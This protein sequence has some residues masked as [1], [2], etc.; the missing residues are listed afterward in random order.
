MAAFLIPIATSSLRGLGHILT[1][2]EAA[3]TPFTLAIPP[4]ELGPPQILSSN[5]VSRDEQGLCGGLLL[6][7]AARIEGQHTISMVVGITNESKFPW[8][9]T[10]QLQLGDTP[11]PVGIGEIPANS[12]REDAVEF[13]L[14]P[15]THELEGS[16]L[17]GP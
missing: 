16:L 15:G 3:E 4:P 5:R 17:I 1:C 7:M 13:D 6:E 14:E 2:R 8:K 11:I 10:I 12:T 9:G